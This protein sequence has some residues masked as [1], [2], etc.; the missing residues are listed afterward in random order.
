MNYLRASRR[1]KNATTRILAWLLSA[2]L[3]LPLVLYGVLFFTDVD[4]FR[5]Q[6]ERHVSAALDRAIQFDGP[7]ILEPS[8]TPR[9]VIEGLSIANPEWASRPS[10]ALV[11]RFKVKVRLLPLLRGELNILALEFHGVDL[12]L[13]E[14]PDDSNNFTFV[15]SGRS[16]L[17][18]AIEYL[19][20]YDTTVAWLPYEG[21]AKSVHLQGVTVRND[22]GQLVEL[23]L[24]TELNGLP[25]QLELLA[26]P[27]GGNWPQGP[28]ETTV[29]AA[30]GDLSLRLLGRVSLPT[31]WYRGVY[32]FELQGES[33]ARL[34]PLLGGD[35]PDAGPYRLGGNIRFNLDDY[36]VIS[37]LSGEIADA[38]L[39][40]SMRWELGELKTR[41]GSWQS[42]LQAG[43]F[44]LYAQGREALW[45]ESFTFSGKL[46][47]LALQRV[48]VRARPGFPL[49]ISAQ[50]TLDDTPLAVSLRAEAL[51]ELVKKPDG[52]WRDLALTAVGEEMELSLSGEVSRPLEAR[53]FDLDVALEGPGFARLLDRPG[54]FALA[55][56]FREQPDRYVLDDISLQVSDTEFSGSAAI[57]Q[58]EDQSL[59]LLKFYR[60]PDLHALLR[61]LELDMTANIS[62]PLFDKS[63]TL[64]GRSLDIGMSTVRVS[65]KPGQPLQ[66]TSEA[67]IEGSAIKLALRGETLERLARNPAGPWRKLKLQGRGEDLSFSLEGDVEQPLAARGVDA[68]IEL[69][70]E[71]I[72][73]LLP[74][75]D[76]VLPL[77]GPYTLS[78]RFKNTAQSAVLD[79]VKINFGRSDIAGRAQFFP[80]DERPRVVM[81]LFSEQLY[82]MEF[83]P[84]AKESQAAAATLRVIPDVR[85]PLERIRQIDAQLRFK[86]KQLRTAVGDL[87]EVSFALSLENQKLDIHEFL[88]RGW[89]DARVQASGS[90]DAAQSPPAIDLQLSA[91]E[92][93]YGALL[94]Q[95]GLAE[96]IEGTL[97][98][99]VA[100]AGNGY[101][102]HELLSNANGK[103]ILVGKQGRFGSRRLDLWGSDLVTTMLSPRW[104]REDVTE[105]NCVVARIRIDNGVASSDTMLVD[106]NRITIGATG[107]LDLQSEKINLV[108]APSPKRSSLVSLANPVVVTGTLSAPEVETTV[109]PRRRLA[110]FG[111]GVLAGLI[112]PSYLVFTFTQLGSGSSNPCVASVEAAEAAKT[113]YF[114]SVR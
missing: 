41:P 110:G 29:K 56:H 104:L 49:A 12:K 4:S 30:L 51:A 80:G 22:P 46:A 99:T 66:L 2:A 36:L 11:E 47:R 52:P 93:N 101:S 95:A 8:L 90:I 34:A 63:L 74:L 68:A 70:G 71:D 54:E 42:V 5:G 17:L 55:G 20:L 3:T 7:I 88:L 40:G 27:A 48:E 44:E 37:D 112:N 103:F 65:V 9:L 15:S 25:L 72:S 105:L 81:D 28:W 24:A 33:L 78:G 82:L 19:L 94:R 18:P 35:L 69:E 57:H 111:G 108:F 38:E 96:S 97:D 89:A 53:G 102:G 32:L 61:Q 87:G 79:D 26:E 73:Q 85:F 43:E 86:G 84:E 64:A 1:M 14:G 13:E 107:I 50:A 45:Q 91:R 31:E 39:G 83:L 109:L 98:V 60:E 113:E 100:L 21:M 106:T 6:V 16:S 76:L 77:Q 67:S 114:E 58:P 10:L 59:T 23:E 75:F 92:L 62:R